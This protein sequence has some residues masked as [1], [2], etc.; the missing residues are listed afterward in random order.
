MPIFKKFYN[1]ADIKKQ[2]DLVSIQERLEAMDKEKIADLKKRTSD[3]MEEDTESTSK[4][5]KTGSEATEA[6]TSVSEPKI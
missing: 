3:A 4:K 2:N 6:T 1:E 5:I